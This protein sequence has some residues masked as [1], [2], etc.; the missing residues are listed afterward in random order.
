M[1]I[2]KVTA[3][4]VQGAGK[5]VANGVVTLDE[6]IELKYTVLNVGKGP[7]ISWQGGKS[8]E[9]KDGTKGWDSPIFITDASLNKEIQEQVFAKLKLPL[10]KSSGSSKSAGKGS[11]TPKY[12][13]SMSADDIPF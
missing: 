12:D 5:V 11:E 1:E 13:T 2:T 4:P 3:F 7:Y 8:Y 10:S 9:K 6:K